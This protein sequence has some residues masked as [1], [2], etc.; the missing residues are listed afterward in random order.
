MQDFDKAAALLKNEAEQGSAEAQMILGCVYITGF[1]IEQDLAKGLHWL[2]LSINQGNEE[3]KGYLM[4]FDQLER[5]W[6]DAPGFQ[7]ELKRYGYES[8][9]TIVYDFLKTMEGALTQTEAIQAEPAYAAPYQEEPAYAA[10]YQAEPTYAAP[11]QEEP[12]YAAP[13]QA[14]PAYAAPHQEEPAYAAP[15]QEEP[16]YAAPFQ[17][18]T[19]AEPLTEP[20]HSQTQEGEKRLHCIRGVF[21]EQYYPIAEAICIGTDPERC[22]IVYSKHTRG[23]SGL[24]CSVNI[25]GDEIHLTDMGSMCGTFLSDGRRLEPHE[26]IRLMPGECF[27]LANTGNVFEIA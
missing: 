23:I 16:T 4:H 15:Y 3:A 21:A 12:T 1:G 5:G 9:S 25:S 24:H 18:G 14:E 27:D 26:S 19:Q 8:I 11:Y 7:E 2:G 13:Y 6:G 22:Q 17:A 20:A 10:P